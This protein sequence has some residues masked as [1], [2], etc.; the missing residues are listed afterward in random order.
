MNMGREINEVVKYH[1]TQSIY[2]LYGCPR[3][4]KHSV[5]LELQDLVAKKFEYLDGLIGLR[6]K[7]YCAGAVVN[8]V[9][10]LGGELRRIYTYKW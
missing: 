8:A 5:G 6:E 4:A 7:A 3:V 1:P 9:S 10:S 2:T